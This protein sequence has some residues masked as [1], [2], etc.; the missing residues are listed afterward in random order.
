MCSK[1]NF[2]LTGAKDFKENS[3][4]LCAPEYLRQ[5]SICITRGRLRALL[6]LSCDGTTPKG[7]RA[8]KKRRERGER[9]MQIA[10]K[11]LQAT[12]GASETMKA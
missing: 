2:C 5:R 4:V 10:P 1:V 12:D 7:G 11:Y 8:R 6:R 3:Y 9:M